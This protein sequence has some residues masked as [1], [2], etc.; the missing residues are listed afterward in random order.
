[1]EAIKRILCATDFSDCS[2]RALGYALDFALSMEARLDVIHILQSGK[3]DSSRGPDLKSEVIETSLRDK[4]RGLL[5]ARHPDSV[6]LPKIHCAS[7][8][9]EI[10]PSAIIDYAKEIGADMIV[11]GTQGQGGVKRLLLGSVAEEVAR[12]ASCLV[13]TVR[14]DSELPPI[15]RILVP[16]DFSDD[17]REALR[18]AR[19]IAAIF[20]AHLELLHTVLDPQPPEFYGDETS[21]NVDVQTSE[22]VENK[23]KKELIAVGGKDGEAV[24]FHVRNGHPAREIVRFEDEYSCDL[25]VMS[26]KGLQGFMRFLLGS[27]T[28]TVMRKATCPILTV[29]MPQK[30]SKESL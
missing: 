23:L 18:Q 8:R 24:S 2:Y 15:Q 3:A 12:T 9:S 27:I 16:I 10:V 22:L 28:E 11:L 7:I 13:M 17:A 30:G 5:D 26:T 6:D 14:E 4:V 25:V 19:E 1:M 21:W 20:G 29:K